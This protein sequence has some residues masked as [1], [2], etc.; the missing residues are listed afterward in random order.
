MICELLFMETLDFI[1]QGDGYHPFV[2]ALD[3]F[4]AYSWLGK[5]LLS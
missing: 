4:T 1:G 2:A 5:T 3:K